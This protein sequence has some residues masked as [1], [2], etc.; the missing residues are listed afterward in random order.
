[1]SG[2]VTLLGCAEHPSLP[3]QLGG[4]DCERGN[5][6]TERTG[7]KSDMKLSLAM[8]DQ[9]ETRAYFASNDI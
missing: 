5:V 1:M 9:A 8:Y 6:V 4:I 2:G 7:D 3:V